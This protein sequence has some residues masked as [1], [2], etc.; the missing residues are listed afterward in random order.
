ML[1]RLYEILS[2][3]SP[4]VRWAD[5]KLAWFNRE[6]VWVTPLGLFLAI[7]LTRNASFDV[8]LYFI[9]PEGAGQNSPGQRPGD[10][11]NREQRGKKP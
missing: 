10:A 8:A 2:N 6:P 4:P 9:R 1:N 7:T 11:K 5:E 3:L